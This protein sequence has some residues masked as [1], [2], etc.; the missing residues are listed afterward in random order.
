MRR[1][2]FE[3][4]VSRLGQTTYAHAS[5]AILSKVS[6]C[7]NARSLLRKRRPDYPN[8]H[9]IFPSQKIR[10]LLILL[11]QLTLYHVSN[12]TTDNNFAVGMDSQR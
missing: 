5:G 8:T 3:I 9:F 2:H 1:P 7:L 11:L 6:P 4:M 12:G 10:I